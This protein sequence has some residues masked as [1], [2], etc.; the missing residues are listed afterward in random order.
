M[1]GI[2]KAIAAACPHETRDSIGRA[3]RPSGR[4]VLAERMGVSVQAVDKFVRQGYLP[5]ERAKQ[6]AGWY[7]VPLR[8]LVKPDI[9]AIL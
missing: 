9:A 6:V 3:S 2:D 7:D 1:T 8:E 5:L 4:V